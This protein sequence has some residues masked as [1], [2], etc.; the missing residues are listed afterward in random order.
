MNGYDAYAK[1]MEYSKIDNSQ[2]AKIVENDP[3]VAKYYEHPAAEL[4]IKMIEKYASL[5]KTVAGRISMMVGDYYEFEDL[6]SFGIFGLLS[7][8]EKY[9]PFNSNGA[10]F[11]TYASLRINGAILDEIRKNDRMSRTTRDRKKAIE[12][13]TK[14]LEGNGLPATKE[15]LAKELGVSVDDIYK[16]EYDIEVAKVAYIDDV[17]ETNDDD[18][19]LFSPKSTIGLPEE[20]VLN[21]LSKKELKEQLEIALNT[22]TEKERMV[23]TLFYYENLTMKEIANVLEI[24]ESR[25]SQLNSRAIIKLREKLGKYSYL[26]TF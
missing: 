17:L 9:D 25:V 14:E 12:K 22:L 3:L 1:Q 2:N 13:A 8:I 19:P 5:I 20:E 21:E 15:N 18:V 26:F 23:V 11:E 16:W 6:C 24:S 7:A 4:K 10:K